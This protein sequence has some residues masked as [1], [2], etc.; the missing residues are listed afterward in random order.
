VVEPEPVLPPEV[1]EDLPL[2]ISGAV[3]DAKT[4]AIIDGATVR[5]IENGAPATNV[6]DLDGN[7]ITSA[8]TVDGSFEVAVKGDSG[9][10]G[11]TAVASASGYLDKSAFIEVVADQDVI[12]AQIE[13]TAVTAAVGVAATEKEETVE[14]ATVAAEIVVDTDDNVAEEDDTTVGS[15]TVTVPTAVVLQDSAGNPVTGTAIKLNVAFVEETDEQ[16]ANAEEATTVA[17]A[18]PPGI[19]EVEDADLADTVSIPLAVAQVNVTATDTATNTTTQVKRFSQPITITFNLP[20]TTRLRSEGRTVAEG[21]QFTVKSFDEDEGF[22]EVEPNKAIVGPEGPK[23]F[24]AEFLVDH[25]TF[26]AVTDGVAACNQPI[27][28]TYG[29]DAVPSSGLFVRIFS[30]D[31][32]LNGFIRAGTT[33]ESL[34]AAEAKSLGIAANATAAV[35]VRD[36]DGNIWAETDGEVEFCGDVALTLANPVELVD[37]N[38]TIT[39]VCSN[40]TTVTTPLTGALVKYRADATRPY[41]IAAGNGNGTYSLLNMVSGTEYSVLVDTRLDGV[42]GLQTTTITADGTGEDLNVSLTCAGGTGTGGTG[43]SGG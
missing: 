5:F 30:N 15:A 34:T 21:D 39:A 10:D 7:A 12:A 27:N 26:F 3:L 18:I 38:L 11:F 35:R 9:I 36:A 42:D 8:T 24:P 32:D 13:L 16:A 40:D 28:I 1:G 20:A 29:G 31:I 17:A 2:V 4:G 22:W 23:G 41:R 19:N 43:G 25:L 33:E 6:V 37:E 14:N